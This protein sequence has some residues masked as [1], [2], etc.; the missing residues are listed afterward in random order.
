MKAARRAS[1]I[2]EEDRQLGAM[3]WDAEASSSRVDEA[4][5][6]TNVGVVIVEGFPTTD[7]VGSRQPDPPS[8]GSPVLCSSGLLHL[9]PYFIYFYALWTIACL[10]VEGGVIGK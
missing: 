3:E 4:D 7:K 2:D 8:C 5:R 9:P 6:S 1:L 10:F